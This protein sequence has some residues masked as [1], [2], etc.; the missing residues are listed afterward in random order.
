[1]DQL[2][3]AYSRQVDDWVR[4][5]L[6]RG[7]TSLDAV[8]AAL[9][10]V[11]PAIVL[12]TLQRVAPTRSWTAPEPILGWPA[13]HPSRHAPPLP[14]PHPLDYDWRFH[15]HATATL[16]QRI[17][18]YAVPDTPVLLLGTPSLLHATLTT[19]RPYT[20][21]LLE[22]NS[23]MVRWFATHAPAAAARHCVIGQD[24]IPPLAGSVVVAD[25][26]WYE[27]S[28]RTFLWAAA[29]LCSPGGIVLISL[30][31]V[32]TRPGMAA[33][34]SRVRAGAQQ[35]G[36]ELIRRERGALPYVT[37]P[38]ERS[39]LQAAGVPVS[40][41][42]WRWGDLATFTRRMGA[43]P[44]AVPMARSEETWEEICVD[45]VRLRL[46]PTTAET[47]DPRLIQLVADHVLPSVSRRDPRRHLV[48][49]WT[50]G[51]RVYA[52]R[53]TA[54]LAALL[55]AHDTQASPLVAA[56]VAS[57]RT[58][59]ATEAACVEIAHRQI[60]ELLTVEQAMLEGFWKGVGHDEPRHDATHRSLRRRTG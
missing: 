33:E 37:P 4:A 9:P 36:L 54:V 60:A 57:G 41:R 13:R 44:V 12:E 28:I 47:I 35:M 18:A 5:A 11:Y 49:V 45:G 31:P 40:E 23:T 46:R 8:V 2:S 56:E 52:C 58:L 6:S 10:G 29:Q 1:M 48:D 43:A 50:A 53:S 39:A 22:A 16:L 19:Q 27:E 38:F 24:P 59:T 34:W 32:G 55:R 30:P 25:P 26:P 51:N 14:A 17:D 42:P 15:E 21:T 7:A 20:P 3:A